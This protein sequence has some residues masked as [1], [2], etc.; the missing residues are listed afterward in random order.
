MSRR[1]QTSEWA[2]AG[3]G[4]PSSLQTCA[5][6]PG[7]PPS[8]LRRLRERRSSEAGRSRGATG[9]SEALLKRRKG[10]ALRD[11]LTDGGSAARPPCGDHTQPG[12][13]RR[14]RS[15]PR[16][17][18]PAAGEGGRKPEAAGG[19][20]AAACYT[21]T[22]QCEFRELCPERDPR[23]RPEAPQAGSGKAAVHPT[24]RRRPPLRGTRFEEEPAARGAQTRRRRPL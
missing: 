18:R 16:E 9:T 20:A 24:A 6:G 19:P 13:P 21:A 3:P 5:A 12:G 11:W 8:L 14:S 23:G 4:F 17:A 1:R 7:Q 22:A 2:S 10:T 15:E